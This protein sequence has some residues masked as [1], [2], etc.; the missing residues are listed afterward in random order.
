MSDSPNLGLPFIEAAQAQKHVTHNEALALLDAVVQIAVSDMAAN[1]PPAT[2]ASGARVIVG[3]APTGLFAG[4]AGRIASYDDAGWRFVSPKGGWIVWSSADS[5]FFV[6]SGSAW[7]KLTDALGAIQNLGMLGVATTADAANPLSVRAPNALFT[8]RY[9]AD[10]GDGSL[11]FKLNKETPAATVSQLYQTNWSGRAETG[12]IGDDLWAVRRSVNGVT[13]TTPFV[14]DAAQAR[15]LDGAPATPG[16]AFMGSPSTGF[17]RGADGAVSASAAGVE[18]WRGATTGVLTIPW[19]AVIGDNSGNRGKLTIGAGLPN[20]LYFSVRG[21]IG[22]WFDGIFTLRDNAGT[23]FNRLQFGGTTNAFPSLKRSGAVLQ[24]RLADDSAFATLEA[25][26]LQVSGAQARVSVNRRDTGAQAG[27]IYSA[28]GALQFRN[29]GFNAD[30]LALGADGLAT[31]AGPLRMASCTVATAPSAAAMGA[32]A[33]IFVSN[34]VGGPV[35]A[36]SDGT[37]WRRVTDRAVIA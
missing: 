3:A 10:G 23:S 28:A 22:A 31:F 27:V 36:F 14:V 21:S 25:E 35:L 5:L 18:V 19:S 6:Y 4:M 1:A 33:T 17:S 12:L 16:L 20:G 24:A 26:T 37:A 13:W 9:A 8:A 11:R 30:V 29:S 34:E 2:P 32:G 7:M 15:V